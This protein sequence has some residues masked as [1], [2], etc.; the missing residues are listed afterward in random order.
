MSK[1]AVVILSRF[2]STRL[3]GKALMKI[4][5]KEVLLYILERIQQVSPLS[6]VVIATSDEHSDDPIA[7]FA[8]EQKVN[9]FR[10]SLNNVSERFLM[11]AKSIGADYACRI[12]GDNIFLDTQTLKS[13]LNLAKEHKYSFL[14]NVK[15][16]T[17]PKGMS[18][19]VVKVDYYER[20]LN[21][22]VSEDGYREHVTLFLYEKVATTDHFYLK[23]NICP[24]AAGIQ[25]ALDTKEDFDRT[26]G[27]L[28][29][30]NM[31]HYK[32]GLREIF[33]LVKL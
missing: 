29:S 7:A 1:T 32:A 23:N 15:G 31:P 27:I 2:S 18:V 9:L 17:F 28:N 25:L 21:Q 14:S 11:A 10:G 24:E 3:P 26:V 30:L 19:E 20:L 16:R 22:I 12:N 5:G 6:N 33:E 4:N 13:L 8:E